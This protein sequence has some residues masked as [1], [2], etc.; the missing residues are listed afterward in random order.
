[1]SDAALDFTDAQILI[2]D[3]V[4]ATIGPLRQPLEAAN[5]KLKA[6]NGQLKEEINQRQ[7]LSKKLSRVSQREAERWSIEGFVG[8]S[9]LLQK[10]LQNIKMLEKADS[11]S[12]LITGESGTGKEL[13]P[14]AIGSTW[15]PSLYTH[16]TP[17]PDLRREEGGGRPPFYAWLKNDYCHLI[18]LA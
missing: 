4:P 9:P 8:Q 11:T 12:V 5:A 6:A 15:P 13:V 17:T 10:I 2:V 3:D 16:A 7:A 1:M 14:H 18:F